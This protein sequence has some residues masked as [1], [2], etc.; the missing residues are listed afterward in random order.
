MNGSA[1]QTVTS[2]SLRPMK[3]SSAWTFALALALLRSKPEGSASAALD[4]FLTQNESILLLPT[5]FAKSPNGKASTDHNLTKESKQFTLRGV[6]YSGVTPDDF[7]MATKISSMLAIALDDALRVIVQTKLRIPIETI[8]ERKLELLSRLPDD[9]ALMAG[10]IQLRTYISAILSEQRTVL[11]LLVE[12]FSARFDE[13]ASS[14]VQNIGNTVSTGDNFVLHSIEALNQFLQTESEVNESLIQKIIAEE[15][16]LRMTCLIKFIFEVILVLGRSLSVVVQKWFAVMEKHSFLQP[17]YFRDSKHTS[18]FLESLCTVTS[19]Q[20]LQLNHDF[21]NPDPELYLDNPETFKFVNG[22]I[23]SANCSNLIKYAWLLICHKKSI[24]LEEFK[25]VLALFLQ[26]VSLSETHNTVNQLSRLLSTVPIFDE[27]L[28]IHK[29]LFFD[30]I[31]SMVLCDLL[32]LALPLI[33]VTDEG[34]RCIREVFSAAPEYCVQSFFKNDEAARNITLSRAKFPHSLSPFLCLASIN[35][36]FA[37]EE[38]SHMKSYMCEFESQEATPKCKIDS[39]DTDLVETEAPFDI[40]PPFEGKNKLSLYLESGTKAKVI[41]LNEDSKTI[42]MF[43]HNYNGWALLGRI[44]ENISK[45]FDSANSA[46]LLMLADTAILI[47]RVCEQASVTEIKSILEYM[48][49]YSDDSDIVEILFRLLE[50]SMHNRCIFQ[51]EKLLNVVS[52]LMP[53][54]SKRVWSYLSSSSLLPSNGKE[55]LA[56]ILFGSI[57]SKQGHYNLSIALVKFVARL[58]DNCL[59]DTTD[60]PESAKNEILE[61]FVRHLNF[62]LESIVNCKFNEGLQKLELGLLILNVFKQILET[63]YGV[64]ASLPAN[65]KPTKVFSGASSSIVNA[66]INTDLRV[67]R[68]A[69]L[70]F[71]LIDY[72]ASS[73]V[74]FESRDP[75][76]FMLNLW[77]N[78]ALAFSKLIIT[79]RHSE[80]DLHSC[81]FENQMLLKLPKLVAIYLKNGVHRKAI[82][83]FLSTLMACS[84]RDKSPSMLSFLGPETANALLLSLATDL[85]NPFDDFAVKISIYDFLCSIMEANEQ[86]LSVLLISGRDVFNEFTSKKEISTSH[87]TTSLLDILK[88]NVNE[89]Q[90][91][92]DSVSVHLLDAI[93]LAFNSWT[94]GRDND[95]D[96]NFVSHLINIVGDFK[97]PQLSAS[98]FDLTVASYKCKVVSKIAEILSLVFFTTKNEKCEKSMAKLLFSDSFIALLPQVFRISDY[99]THLFLRVQSRF[100]RAFPK[101]KLSQF[102]TSIQKRNR[103]GPE[104]IYDLGIMDCLFKNHSE[105][106]DIRHEIMLCSDNIQYFNVQVSLA[107]S[108]GALLTTFCRR[109]RTSLSSAYFDLIPVL[110][111]IVDPMDVYSKDFI[112]QQ[113]FER[114]ELAFYLGYAVSNNKNVEKSPKTAISILAACVDIL[115]ADSHIDIPLNS[116]SGEIHKSLLRTCY[117]ALATLKDSSDLVSTSFNVVGEFFEHV[118]AKGTTDIIIEL[119]NDVYLSRTKKCTSNFNGKLDYLRLILSILK[120]ILSF[121][122]VPSSRSRLIEMLASK[123]TIEGLRSLYSFSHL[124]LVNDD[125]VFAQLSLM[126]T[127]QLMLNE[128]FLRSHVDSR[129]FIVIRESVISQPL[130]EGGIN[131]ENAPQLHQNWTNGILPIL[132][133]CLAK[134]QCVNEVLLTLKVFS[135]QIEYC[136]DLWSRDSSSLKV[137]SANVLETVQIIYIYQFLSSMAQSQQ[138]SAL[139]PSEVDMPFIP[140]LDTPQKRDDFVNFISNLLKHPKFF[141]SR[142]VASSAEEKAMMKANDKE[143]SVFARNLIDEVANLKELIA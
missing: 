61:A 72:L 56:S 71:Q 28:G 9:S 84:G 121:D 19:L 78:S 80:K 23:L 133:T 83:D 113:R 128:S 34:A 120:L 8:S 31:F 105:W 58:A 86:G 138:L 65:E 6:V 134:G 101:H 127:Q 130:K 1:L 2:L 38:L 99:D 91:Y 53:V 52:Y 74:S 137:S 45:S 37:L 70:I 4:E 63:V 143:F 93:A 114:V 82:L 123:G 60:Y 108:F 136:V 59:S 90:T 32:L 10:E 79:V 102:A 81:S 55:G 109:A 92:P 122:L 95:S 3:Q 115:R 77:V 131:I 112:A 104:A 132:V 16:L 94:T 11:S 124:I 107:K 111:N 17:S 76:S 51:A 26:I 30:D 125:P 39:D 36:R 66:F 135:K 88:R 49:A 29:V 54:V 27:I 14:V 46:K 44:L 126:F 142:I 35:G 40:Y 87:Q 100:E 103:F 50:Q 119:Q 67:S 73:E 47:E 33:T 110:L 89:I 129:L 139:S 140:G 42:F 18:S 24:V 69:E 43:V 12:C 5:P 106:Q 75:T 97:K 57:E 7:E 64:A 41:N 85:D 13:N 96:V 20:L 141:V 22:V 68:S 15:G 118:V 116:R 48:S 21:G 62:I 98:S 25:E 117:L